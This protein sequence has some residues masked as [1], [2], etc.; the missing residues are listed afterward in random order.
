MNKFHIFRLNFIA[1]V[2]LKCMCD[3]A[4]LWFSNGYDI[5]SV[6]KIGPLPIKIYSYAICLEEEGLFCSL[7]ENRDLWNTSHHSEE[8]SHCSTTTSKR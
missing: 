2:C 6:G 8:G 5:I 1:E 4:N 7:A 3:L